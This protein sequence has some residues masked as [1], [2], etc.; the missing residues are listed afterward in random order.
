MMNRPPLLTLSTSYTPRLALLATLLT[1]LPGCDKSSEQVKT[2]S[3][4]SDYRVQVMQLKAAS[5]RSQKVFTGQLQST[6]SAAVSFRVPGTIQTIKVK[7]GDTVKKGQLLA[8]LD[9]H[10]YEVALEEL[11]ARALEAKSA[12]KLAKIELARV[13]Q[14]IDD[15]AIAGV[16]LD[17]AI[18]GFER[19]EA[20]VKVVDQNILRAKDTISYTQLRAPFDGVIARSNYDQFEQ[21]LPGVEVFTVHQPTQLEVSVDVPENL[22]HQFE[23]NQS[24]D[25]SWYNASTKLSGKATEIG[26]LPHPIKQTYTVTFSV[27][28]QSLLE[29]EV[30]VLPGKA[31]TLTTQLGELSTDFCVPYSAIVGVASQQFIYVVENNRSVQK[32]IEVT[33]LEANATCVQADLKAGDYV[34]V[35]GASYL[36]E[37]QAI[38]SMQVKTFEVSN[39]QS[40]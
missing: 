28:P 19:S 16:N 3:E 23:N 17:R 34:V 21:I 20:A 35:S 7:T 2:P 31:V 25:I 13:Q 36:K 14:A 26:S 22:I 11:N 5:E 38:S 8:E 18:S 30:N 29:N 12:F 10:D 39:V 9:P 6:K 40:R 24:A 15:N 1:I 32:P 4:P 37:N 27:D 33:S